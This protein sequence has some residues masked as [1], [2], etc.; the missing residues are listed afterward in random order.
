VTGFDLQQRF[1]AHLSPITR[2]SY[3]M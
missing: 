3:T 2:G 1:N